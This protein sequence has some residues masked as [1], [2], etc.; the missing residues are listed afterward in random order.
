MAGN[1]QVIVDLAKHAFENDIKPSARRH[2]RT[3]HAVSTESG[4]MIA[5]MTM[6][7]GHTMTLAFA[8][9]MTFAKDGSR[10]IV[11]GILKDLLLKEM[12]RQAAAA[13]AFDGPTLSDVHAG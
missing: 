10:P 6:L 11:I 13:L 9:G 5:F 12:E 4:D 1:E 7:A 8:T 2:A 3:L